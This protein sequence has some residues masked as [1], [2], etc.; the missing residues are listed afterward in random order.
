MKSRVFKSGNSMAVRIP[1]SMKWDASEVEIVDLG[2][3]GLL[4]KPLAEPRD[5]WELFREGLEEL[6]GDWPDRE[7][8]YDQERADW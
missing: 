8:E 3:E 2:E 6:G 7:Q 1:A 5:P 4:I